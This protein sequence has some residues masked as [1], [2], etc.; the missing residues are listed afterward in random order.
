MNYASQIY[1]FLTFDSG[2]FCR[3]SNVKIGQLLTIYEL[4]LIKYMLEL[5][6]GDAI[7]AKTYG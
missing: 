4:T 5:A 1:K 7:C 2:K 6:L 3:Y